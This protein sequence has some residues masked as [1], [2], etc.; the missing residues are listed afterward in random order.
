M[1]TK[2]NLHANHRCRMIE[3]FSNNPNAFSEHELLEILLFPLI[4]RKNT[5]DI[6]HMLIKTFGSIKNV[7]SA[8]PKELCSVKGV[9]VKTASYIALYGKIF[10][11]ISIKTKQ[12]A[13]TMGF[14]YESNLNEILENFIGLKVELFVLYLLDKNYKVITKI[15]YTNNSEKDVNGNVSEIVK[16]MA[17]NNP[18]YAIMCH[19]HPFGNATP[20][21]ND[22]LSTVKMNML[23]SLH[24]VTLLDHVIV[25]KNFTS[26]SYHA[27][28]KMFDIKD[29]Y[30]INSLVKNKL[31]EEY[32]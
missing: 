18:A 4:P 23:C 7:L 8:S 25:G 6:A 28:G 31:E 9:G 3:K 32:E 20:S 16:A 17:I 21:T 11:S 30:E 10:E 22:N 2:E 1:D 29:S 5:N 14:S 24:G 26:Y 12:P 27:S 13:L 15:K 19:N